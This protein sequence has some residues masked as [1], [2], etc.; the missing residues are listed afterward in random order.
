[1]DDLKISKNYLMNAFSEF[2]TISVVIHGD[3]SS[4]KNFGMI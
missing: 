4:S 1:M 2:R 3:C